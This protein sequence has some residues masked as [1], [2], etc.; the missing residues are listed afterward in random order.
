MEMT[1]E[2]ILFGTLEADQ[3]EIF[4]FCDDPDGSGLLWFKPTEQKVSIDKYLCIGTDQQ[5][6]SGRCIDTGE[7]ISQA[8]ELLML[9]LKRAPK[10]TALAT[11]KLSGSVG[12]RTFE[13][14]VSVTFYR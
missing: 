11:V 9:L 3:V 1:K 6:Y 2:K 14:I 4:E 10:G 12:T 5:R 8:G 13:E 7:Y